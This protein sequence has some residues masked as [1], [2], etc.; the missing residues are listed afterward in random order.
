MA[1]HLD[2]LLLTLLFVEN[3]P[4]LFDNFVT[5]IKLLW[6]ILANHILWEF[7]EI[8]CRNID[9]SLI[10]LGNCFCHWCFTYFIVLS[11]ICMS[12]MLRTLLTVWSFWYLWWHW[13]SWCKWLNIWYI[14]TLQLIYVVHIHLVEHCWVLSEFWLILIKFQFGHLLLNFSIVFSFCFFSLLL[15]IIGFLLLLN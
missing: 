1:K 11:I 6:T 8:T 12:T 4:V 15:F 2:Q 5:F 14:I 13:L 3:T 7:W 9:H 10:T